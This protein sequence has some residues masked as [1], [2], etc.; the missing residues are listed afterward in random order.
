MQKLDDGRIALE[1]VT[2]LHNIYCD[3]IKDIFAA[4]RRACSDHDQS[5]RLK[6]PRHCSLEAASVVEDFSKTGIAIAQN[7]P[8][9]NYIPAADDAKKIGVLF[10]H[11]QQTMPEF[12]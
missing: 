6:K 4:A 3:T 12:A 5:F 11:N 2:S 7:A 1:L 8:I 9:S 10:L